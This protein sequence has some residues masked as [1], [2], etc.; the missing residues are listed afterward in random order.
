MEP[1]QITLRLFAASQMLLLFCVF[2]M[3]DNPKRVRLLGCTLMFAVIIYFVEPMMVQQ[4]PLTN[5]KFAFV[6]QS[7]IP[8]LTLIF[9]WSVFED[10]SPIPIWLWALVGLD[11]AL[12]LWAASLTPSV[13]LLEGISQVVKLTMAI[14]AVVVVWKGRDADLIEMRSKTRMWFV[15]TF[16]ITVLAVAIKEFFYIFGSAEPRLIGLVWMFFISLAANVLFFRLNPTLKL[17]EESPNVIPAEPI[18]D[19]LVE[20]LVQKMESER[21]YA[22]HDLRVGSLA[23]LMGLPEYQLRKKIN[24]TLGFRNFNQF[25]N[26]YRI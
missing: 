14:A 19:P 9:V 26:Q 25:V 16:V 21:W 5:H 13:P 22:D 24:Q 2:L 6:F 4:I 20:E 3:S 15:G 1:I 8:A 18:A 17:V 10:G 12:S 23:D 11:L 7:M